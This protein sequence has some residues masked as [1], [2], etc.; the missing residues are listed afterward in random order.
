LG[1]NGRNTSRWRGSQLLPLPALTIF[2]IESR[3]FVLPP[4]L[5][6][7][8]STLRLRASSSSITTLH[9]SNIACPNAQWV[10]LFSRI[11]LFALTDLEIVSETLEFT[12]LIQFLSRHSTITNLYFQ[13][14]EVH[15]PEFFRH[16]TGKFVLPN[17]TTLAVTSQFIYC[18]FSGRSAFPPLQSV[19]ILSYY[20]SRIYSSFHS[21]LHDAFRALT[22][23]CH[24]KQV[25]L[26]LTPSKESFNL[27]YPR[28]FPPVHHLLFLGHVS[29]PSKEKTINFLPQWVGLFPAV[30]HVSIYFTGWSADDCAALVRS[31]SKA[32]PQMDTVTIGP[33]RHSLRV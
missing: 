16:P 28:T 20:H 7:T 13:S 21:S 31:I 5:G 8:L 26:L 19:Q 30:R 4:F 1:L 14:A 24:A 18:L 2:S 3:L 27:K 15:K 25:C 17:L 12:P 23:I 33:K 10:Q 6:W 29:N 9:F 32:C 22:P 11:T